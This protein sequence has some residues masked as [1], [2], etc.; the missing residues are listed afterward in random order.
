[1]EKGHIVLN[2]DSYEITSVSENG[3]NI[4][5]LDFISMK[6]ITYVGVD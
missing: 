1:M 4:V 2:K 6:T 5:P 3:I